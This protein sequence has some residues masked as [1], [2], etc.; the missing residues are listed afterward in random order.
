LK[1]I[2]ILWESIIDVLERSKFMTI[3][4]DKFL[5]ITDETRTRVERIS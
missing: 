5:I 4:S 2:I 1:G 3:G